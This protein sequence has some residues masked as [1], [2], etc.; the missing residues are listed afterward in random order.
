MANEIRRTDFGLYVGIEGPKQLRNIY[1]QRKAIT[2]FA[3]YMDNE[4]PE[5]TSEYMWTT[6]DQD[7]HRDTPEQRRPRTDFAYVNREDLTRLG[8]I[9]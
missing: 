2:D 6:K 3:I 7:R 8:N 9:W 5:E 1:G 4:G